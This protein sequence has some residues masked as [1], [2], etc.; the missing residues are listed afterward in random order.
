MKAYEVLQRWDAAEPLGR[1]SLARVRKTEKPSSVVL[2]S[3]LAQFALTLTKQS[4]WS[5]AEPVLR[6]CLAIREQAI[7]NDW[8]RFNTMGQLGGALLGQG[9]FAEAE[10]L[11]VQ[12]YEG[13][14]AREQVIPPPGRPRLPEA[15]ERAIR[16][17][18]AW[19]K[20]EKV[21]EWKA[22]VGLADLP[23]VVFVQP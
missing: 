2:A 19:G 21:I 15:A 16:L 3:E 8:P 13:T 20:P 14:K 10:L 23:K 22:K 11:I 17:Y 5:E 7:P 9:K 18:E 1:D 6:E 12:G 4:K